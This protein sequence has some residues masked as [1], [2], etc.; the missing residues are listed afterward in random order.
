MAI[1]LLY[2]LVCRQSKHNLLKNY[3]KVECKFKIY[4]YLINNKTNKVNKSFPPD[5]YLLPTSL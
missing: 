2:Y 4:D 5:A 3:V 1:S